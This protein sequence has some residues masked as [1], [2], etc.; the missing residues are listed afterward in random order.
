MNRP[1][2]LDVRGAG[3]VV[4]V[5]HGVGEHSC[6]NI[7]S[8]AER[9]F[10]RSR[11]AGDFQSEISSVRIK[12]RPWEIQSCLKLSDGESSHFLIPCV[13]SGDRMGRSASN[14][15]LVASAAII[16][17]VAALVSAG[18]FIK[19]LEVRTVIP[20]LI[21]C[22]VLDFLCLSGSRSDRKKK[23]T[24]WPF[25]FSLAACIYFVGV[26]IFNATY[27]WVWVI[28][29]VV[30]SAF[31]MFFL[32]LGLRCAVLADGLGWKFLIGT[33]AAGVFSLMS[34][35]GITLGTWLR[36]HTWADI[37]NLEFRD[38][39]ILLAWPL[40]VCASMGVLLHVLRVFTPV[41]LVFDIVRFV[42]L[43]R[44]RDQLFTSL[45]ALVERISKQAPESQII[46]V[47]HS[48]GSVLASHA[49]LQFASHH[50]GLVS[51]V[52]M[53]SPLEFMSRVFP[54][55]VRSPRG[56]ARDF[57]SN[58]NISF[59]LNLWRDSDPV[60][61]A[62]RAGDVSLFREFSL[63]AGGH[64]DY[65]SDQ[66][67]WD[68]IAARIKDR[69]LPERSEPGPDSL[70][71]RKGAALMGAGALTVWT[72]A[73]LV[74]HFVELKPLSGPTLSTP[75]VSLQAGMIRGRVVDATGQGVAGVAIELDS[76]GTTNTTADGSFL[77]GNV[78]AKSHKLTVV[79][80]PE[81]FGIGKALEFYKPPNRQEIEVP[82][83]KPVAVEFKLTK[84]IRIHG[85]VMS[86]GRRGYVS[87]ENQVPSA[88]GPDG[89]FEIKW[90]RFGH[91]CRLR[92]VVFGTGGRT[93]TIPIPGDKLREGNHHSLGEIKL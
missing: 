67:V 40:I 52:T 70:F 66:R 12:Q 74:F 20:V 54:K 62:L 34:V 31:G 90:T 65:W 79:E 25:P 91:D 37:S 87:A 17:A 51:L 33:L 53:G 29:A 72:L 89:A 5:I 43:S 47:S 48:L 57:T 39:L 21:G 38:T 85:T 44:K 71:S 26:Y 78:S 1:P 59:W 73:L 84:C 11:I 41:E 58:G 13:W 15:L 7:T 9:G 30:L 64:S 36:A 80:T 8:L 76:N 35:F 14:M 49:C 2:T 28:P 82:E 27:S 77:F 3:S 4:L 75:P 50:A 22:V 18:F 88:F 61:R 23:E 24:F 83:G 32:F 92:I 56:L 63:G 68:A 69:E 42:A 45:L 10:K 46:L 55:V 60:G 81:L 6:R 19:W 93:N 16:V 86:Q